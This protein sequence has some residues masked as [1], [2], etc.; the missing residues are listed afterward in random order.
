MNTQ[1]VKINFLN[2]TYRFIQFDKLEEDSAFLRFSLAGEIQL[3][4][5]IASVSYWEIATSPESRQERDHDL[6][7][8]SR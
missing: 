4:A 2:N 8:R 5:A 1:R 3:V 7:S 6:F